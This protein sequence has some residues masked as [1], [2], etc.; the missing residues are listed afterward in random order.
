MIWD[1]K[2]NGEK[3]D[4]GTYYYERDAIF[5]LIKQEKI[6]GCLLLGGHDG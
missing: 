4:W 2:K 6:P 1:D 5:D 3:D